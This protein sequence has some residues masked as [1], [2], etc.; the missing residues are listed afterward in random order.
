MIQLVSN[1]EALSAVSRSRINTNDFIVPIP[2]AHSANPIAHRIKHNGQIAVV[3][4]QGENI[5]GGIRIFS[6]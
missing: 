5:N 1:S 2:Y 6:K 4:E 3:V